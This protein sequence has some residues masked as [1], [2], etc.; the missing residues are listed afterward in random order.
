MTVGWRR[1][2]ANGSGS[3]AA[4]F[5]ELMEAVAKQAKMSDDDVSELRAKVRAAHEG[6]TAVT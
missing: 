6:L 4:Y 5:A 2:G 1:T 3:E